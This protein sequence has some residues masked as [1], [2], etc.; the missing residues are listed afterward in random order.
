M[1]YQNLSWDLKIGTHGKYKG[2]TVR[3][4]ANTPYA[5]RVLGIFKE[6]PYSNVSTSETYNTVKMKYTT[7]ESSSG[8]NLLGNFT[9]SQVNYPTD[10]QLLPKLAEKWHQSEFN[11]GVFIGEGRETARFIA[12]NCF[13]LAQSARNLRR[14]NLRGALTTLAGVPR[15]SKRAAQQRLNAKDGSGAWLELQYGWMPLVNDIYAASDYL[16]FKSQQNVVR[17]SAYNEGTVT[18]YASNAKGTI[19]R[20]SQNR[21]SYHIKAVM[22][23]D[24]THYE[25]LGLTNPAGVIWELVPWS[26]VADWFLPIGD[27]IDALNAAGLLPC[28]GGSYTKISK[29]RFDCLIPKGSK[30]SIYT[31]MNEGYNRQFHLNMVRT[32]FTSLPSPLAI[33]SQIPAEIKNRQDQDI[34]R[35]VTAAALVHQ[36]LKKLL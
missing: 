3:V 19:L 22:S 20:A 1:S 17:T 36:N 11:A 12:D 24:P 27:T 30:Y 6:N 33:L 5:D 23:R 14:G 2:S 26:F 21:Y 4:G 9:F 16:K 32:V 28:T 29:R 18:P 8:A 15:R 10:I 35:M 34:K 13:K 7:V 31:T 25:R